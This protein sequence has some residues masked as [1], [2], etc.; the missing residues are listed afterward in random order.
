MLID[1]KFLSSIGLSVFTLPFFSHKPIFAFSVNSISTDEGFTFNSPSVDVQPTG[2]NNVT[3][4]QVDGTDT[5]TIG[6]G[7]GESDFVGLEVN[8][9]DVPNVIQYAGANAVNSGTN[10]LLPNQQDY[11]SAGNRGLSLSTGLNKV[12]S[13]DQEIYTFPVIT[14]DSAKVGDGLV[15]FFVAD[16]AQ[17][18]SLDSWEFL[19]SSGNTVASI[20]PQPH[21]AANPDWVEL[22]RQDL[23][24]VNTNTGVVQSFDNRSV[25]GLALELS[26]F[27]LEGTSNPLT[28]TE[29]SQISSLRI[30]VGET[31]N[32]PPRTDYAFFSADRDSIQLAAGTSVVVPFEFSPALGL[33]LSGLSLG[34][35]KLKTK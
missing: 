19:D 15:D 23:E 30:S 9:V 20:V 22:G 14:I 24:R 3:S 18:Q 11:I 31:I 12:A 8:A 33:I 2:L 10:F 16:I 25:Y 4:F 26:D 6:N 35:Y 13:Q 5:Y 32:E 28:S 21:N 7:V 27:T 34:F 17:N 29:A 1:R